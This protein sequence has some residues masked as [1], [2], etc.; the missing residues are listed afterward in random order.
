[1]NYQQH[2]C[3]PPKFLSEDERK[4]C[5]KGEKPNPSDRQRNC[6][7]IWKQKLQDARQKMEEA[8]GTDDS[9]DKGKSLLL[10]EADE[11]QSTG[12]A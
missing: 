9:R 5:C 12:S 8:G 1:M 2:P 7:E 10:V 3:E 6:V 4:E 11:E